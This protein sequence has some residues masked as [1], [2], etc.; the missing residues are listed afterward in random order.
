[1]IA[2]RR[3]LSFAAPVAL[4]AIALPARGD[5]SASPQ[6]T[7]VINV[8]SSID[9]PASLPALTPSFPSEA[10]A[11]ANLGAIARDTSKDTGLRIRATRAMAGYCTDLPCATT[12]SQ[13]HVD[14]RGI[15]DGYLANPTPAPA[16]LMLM[17]AAVESLGAASAVLP[18]DLTPLLT[19]LANPSRDVRA[20]VVHTLATTCSQPVLDAVIALKKTE[21]TGQVRG[22]LNLA[23]QAITAC[24]NNV[25]Q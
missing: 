2:V 14:L 13:V 21:P 24:V 25:N 10:D 17:R 22:E 5:G 7:P 4:L 18:D 1:M 9:T 11:Q 8:L 19:L 6:L 3:A 20:T 12:T 15:I 16:D 23:E